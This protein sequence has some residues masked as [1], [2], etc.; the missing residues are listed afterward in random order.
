MSGGRGVRAPVES[1][2]AP[3]GEPLFDDN[4]LETLAYLNIIA[5]KILSGQL[6]AERRSR[7]K[8]VSVEFAD[9]RPYA[10]GDDFRFIDWSVYFR[11]DHLFL[12]L[13]EE[14]E[15]LHI[16]LLLDCSASMGFGDP[17]KFLYARRLAAAIG[18]LGLASLDRVHVIPFVDDVPGAAADT[19]R[20]RGKAK[21]FQLLHFLEGRRSGGVTD[22]A[23]ALRRFGASRRKRG[24]VILFTDLYDR[25]GVIPGLNALRYQKF[26]PYVIHIVSPQEAEPA[27]LGDLRLIDGETG[28][29]RDVT[30]T[31]GLLRRY[32]QAFAAHGDRVERYCRSHGMGYARCVTST[33]F[34][35][36]VVQMLRRGKLLQ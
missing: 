26:D 35:E 9:H 18:Y 17:D 19:L 34:Q 7:K 31:E 32:R 5:R 36:T 20:I 22:M 15:D 8:G 23:A 1:R 6:K 33:P 25:D 10:P 4:F 12:K 21:V 11:T 2:S 14:E 16:Y 24:M 28:R 27:L 13:F 30:V 3:A 29:A